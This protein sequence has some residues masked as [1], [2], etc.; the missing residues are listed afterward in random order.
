MY[1]EEQLS[2]LNILLSSKNCIA[3]LFPP[4]FMLF[5]C[6]H[7]SDQRCK[8]DRIDKYQCEKINAVP[9]IISSDGLSVCVHCDDQYNESDQF[10]RTCC[11]QNFFVESS[12][13]VT[14]ASI[15]RSN[16]FDVSLFVLSAT[17]DVLLKRFALTRHTHPRTIGSKLTLEKAIDIDLKN[18]DDIMD[19]ID[20]F[21]DTSNLEVKDL[22]S[23]LY[24]ILS[25]KTANPTITF[26]SYGIKNGVPKGLDTSF[27]VRI[28]PNPF[29]VEELKELNGGDQEVIDYMLTYPI[30]MDTINHIIDYLDFYLPKLLIKDRA[31]YNIGIA[32]SG[33]HHRSTFVANYLAD[34]YKEKYNTSVL[35]NN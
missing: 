9:G 15:T 2:S 16:N 22:R 28:I 3:I 17:K 1:D 5:F 26:I 11:E 4:F 33:G 24:H 34:H 27:D 8:H 18:V 13:Q 25:G 14:L 31:N 10:C 32:C 30:T 35:N 6:D 7:H 29:W 20:C 21:L 12:K 19:D 23:N